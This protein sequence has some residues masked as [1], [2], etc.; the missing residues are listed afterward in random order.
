MK[1]LIVASAALSLCASAYA[2]E[3]FEKVQNIKGAAY[4]VSASADAVY[5]SAD[6]ALYRREGLDPWQKI[7][8]LRKAQ[9]N[10]NDVAVYGGDVW[11]A[12][13]DGVYRQKSRGEFEKVF[14]RSAAV[15]GDESEES[16]GALRCTAIAAGKEG[17]WV[18]SDGGVFA[19]R[20]AKDFSRVASI[21][22]ETRVMGIAL[23]N[24]IVWVAAHDG[25]YA[26]DTATEQARK[27]FAAA[28]ELSEVTAV[29]RN[30][31]GVYAGTASGVKVSCDGGMTWSA[32]AESRL[33]GLRV[34]ALTVTSELVVVAS[35]SGVWKCDAAGA[36][37]ERMTE[38][39]LDASVSDVAISPDG[40]LTVATP[41][42]VFETYV[43]EFVSADNGYVP[44][45]EMLRSAVVRY[46]EISPS[47]IATWRKQ[48]KASALMPTFSVDY[49]QN[50][51]GTS[52]TGTYDGKHYRAPNTWG[53]G[54]S[55]D[56]SKLIWSSDETAIDNRS[57]LNTQLRIDILDEVT[58]LYFERKRSVMKM[59][60]L[61]P[62]HAAFPEH[63]LRVE[64][65]TAAI[66]AYCGGWFSQ[67]IEKGKE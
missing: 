30:E 12:T 10:V 27:V 50:M 22:A 53:M 36:R 7:W 54:V 60:A 18:G 61:G 40:D 1:R 51:Y 42:G 28:E 32:F 41:K 46:N 63:Q 38:G 58:R 43:R 37:C 55:W 15:D 47:K 24:G 29:A 34:Y 59:A 57:R 64:E 33:H 6:D 20:G 9:M 13:D 35:G 19:S 11:L 45:I 26:I 23:G 39:L 3:L 67:A 17:V 66:D 2:G 8:T 48:Y 65:L 25:L 21:A 56:A 31:Y 16:G 62:A 4:A 49:D 52:G 5:A 44:T 14:G